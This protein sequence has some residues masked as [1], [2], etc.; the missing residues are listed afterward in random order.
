MDY[1]FRH[2]TQRNCTGGFKVT[3]ESQRQT[4]VLGSPSSGIEHRGVALHHI[5]DFVEHSRGE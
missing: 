3:I 4:D 2:D 5:I 1:R